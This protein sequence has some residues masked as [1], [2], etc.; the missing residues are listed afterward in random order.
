V[1][2]LVDTA[3]WLWT[4]FEPHR[5]SQ[6]ARDIFADPNQEMFLSAA[7][8][9][10]IAIKTG[11]GKLRLPEPPASYLPRRMADQGVRPL[12]IVHQHALAVSQL[13][14]HHRDPVDRLIIAQA[15]LESMVLM[16]ADAS[17]RRYTVELLWAGR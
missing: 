5:L 4:T 13:P 2:Y 8:A 7:S 9:W 17:F 1:R 14:L 11:S 12:A 10:E 16:T 6:H 3:V 15:K